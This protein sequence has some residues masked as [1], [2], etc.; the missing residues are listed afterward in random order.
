MLTT[1]P[2]QKL[3]RERLVKAPAQFRAASAHAAETAL[4]IVDMLAADAGSMAIFENCL[5]ERGAR[6]VQAAVK[7]VAMNPSSYIVTGRLRL[8]LEP[9]SLRF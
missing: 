7:H 3:S 9:G 8:G 5:L 4:H 6:D 2:V 1:N